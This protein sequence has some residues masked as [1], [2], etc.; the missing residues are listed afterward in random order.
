MGK[1]YRGRRGSGRRKNKN[2]NKRNNG[3]ENDVDILQQKYMEQVDDDGS[4]HDQTNA[5]NMNSVDALKNT[6]VPE[7][8]GTVDFDAAQ[9]QSNN[10]GRGTE[11]ANLKAE[12]GQS[13]LDLSA[14]ERDDLGL[15]GLSQRS[16]GAAN[17]SKLDLSLVE[18]D[19]E[20]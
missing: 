15:G 6:I 11:L 19:L 16:Q 4:Q 2:K 3:P 7:N 17:K 20:K 14:I 12:G 8:F 18:K 5:L 13:L 1:D 9:P 10:P